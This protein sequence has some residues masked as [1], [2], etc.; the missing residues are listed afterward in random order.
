MSEELTD[1]SKRGRLLGWLFGLLAVAALAA[2][3][4]HFGDL[5]IFLQ[6]ARRAQPSWLLAALALQC[7]TYASVA[8]GW[9]AVLHRAD[10]PQPLRALLPIA[11]SKLFADQVL[12]TAGMGGKRRSPFRAWPCGSGDAAA[13]RFLLRSSECRWSEACFASWARRRQSSSRIAA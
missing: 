2:A 4:L 11:L 8:T 7:A 13:A 6:L 5:R 3:V 12:P 10:S 1:A 9:R